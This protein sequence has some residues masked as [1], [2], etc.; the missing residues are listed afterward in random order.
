MKIAILERFE[1]ISGEAC[2]HC[3]TL[4]EIKQLEG[5]LKAGVMER[6]GI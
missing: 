2:E 5:D 6:K 1:H 3:G 4:A